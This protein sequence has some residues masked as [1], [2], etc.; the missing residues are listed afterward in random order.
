MKKPITKLEE[1]TQTYIEEKEIAK[2]IAGLRTFLQSYM[3]SLGME[4]G[5]PAR[6]NSDWH[7]EVMR[8]ESMP[9]TWAA[10]QEIWNASWLLD[11][12]KNIESSLEQIQTCL[13]EKQKLERERMV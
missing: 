11:E 2:H 8:L 9:K 3:F 5:I 13:L 7:A 10:A 6:T 1:A 4:H 12:V